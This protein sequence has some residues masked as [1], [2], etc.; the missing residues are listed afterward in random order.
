MLRA[1]AAISGQHDCQL[2]IAGSGPAED[3]LARQ[4]SALGLDRRVT[5]AGYLEGA[6]LRDAYRAADVF[7]FPSYREGF[8]TAITEAMA[9]GLPVI[10][11]PTRGMVDHLV[12]GS[13]TLFVAPGDDAALTAGL[14]ELLQDPA[15]RERMS[16]ANRAKIA[17]F[18]PDTVA[19]HY[20]A[21]LEELIARPTTDG[22]GARTSRANGAPAK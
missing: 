14:D 21:A 6:P 9:E 12:E 10:T 19:R 11:T 15:L 16:I 1:F 3:E 5:L 7:V 2:V 22:T 18:A 13:N 4:V 17:D 8:P 20:L